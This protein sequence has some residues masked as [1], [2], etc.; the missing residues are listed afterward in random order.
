MSLVKHIDDLRVYTSDQ[1]LDILSINETRLDSS[2]KDEE[3]E[4]SGYKIIRRDRN[5]FGGG[6][7]LYVR[8]SINVNFRSDLSTDKLEAISIEIIKPKINLL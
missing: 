4:L 3:V 1:R 7:A 8:N 2:I 6:V 5:R